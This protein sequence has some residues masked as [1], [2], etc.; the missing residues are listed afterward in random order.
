MSIEGL[1]VGMGGAVA[2]AGLCLVPGKLLV[3]G[4]ARAL[5][6]RLLLGAWRDM[7]LPLLQGRLL[8]L[9]LSVSGRS[10]LYV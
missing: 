2:G 8:R 6:P 1:K 10:K 7:Q 5:L 3:L 4:L 9:A